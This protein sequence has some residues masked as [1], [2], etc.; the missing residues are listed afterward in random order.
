MTK[1]ET[2]SHVPGGYVAFQAAVLL[3]LPR[4]IEIDVALGW[5]HNG[6]SLTRALREA[7]MPDGK[8][9]RGQRLPPPR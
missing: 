5:T 9:R 4:D 1:H 2:A 6:E 7:L 8:P 3:A